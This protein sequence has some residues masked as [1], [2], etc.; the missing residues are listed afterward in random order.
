MPLIDVPHERERST[1]TDHYKDL[2]SG[3]VA[4][5]VFVSGRRSP[6]ELWQRIVN[7]SV[8]AYYEIAFASFGMLADRDMAI[9]FVATSE[10]SHMV[11]DAQAVMI[12]A[13]DASITTP[14]RI[15]DAMANDARPS[16]M[17]EVLR[18][19]DTIAQSDTGRSVFAFHDQG[20][21]HAVVRRFLS[22]RCMVSS[23]R[24]AVLA[25]LEAPSALGHRCQ[26]IQGPPGTGKTST[27]IPLLRVMLTLQQQTLCA[28]PS[29]V[30]VC[31]LASRTI[32][33]SLNNSGVLPP[34]P[35]SKYLL[36]GSATMRKA[37][38]S[39]TEDYLDRIYIESRLKRLRA[40]AKSWEGSTE[41]L[42]QL[43]D[44]PPPNDSAACSEW[45]HK[46]KTTVNIATAEIKGCARVVRDEAPINFCER[47]PGELIRLVEELG[48]LKAALEAGT[49]PAVINTW[50]PCWVQAAQVMSLLRGRK[51][52]PVFNLKA[53]E[54]RVVDAASL[55]FCTVS[56]RGSKAMSDKCFDVVIIDEAAQ[57]VEAE[58]LIVLAD[59]HIKMLTLCGDHKQL[60]GTVISQ[61]AQS[62]GYGRSLFERVFLQLQRREQPDNL[63]FTLLDT[64]FRMH[65]SISAW[66]NQRFYAGRLNDGVN[67]A[68]RS[69]SLHA[70]VPVCAVYDVSWGQEERAD[71]HSVYNAAEAEFVVQL[72]KELRSA[73]TSEH[74]PLSVGIITPYRAHAE[75]LRKRVAS[76]SRVEIQVATVD[77]FQGKEVDAVIFSSVRVKNL[78]FT[79]DERRLN[80]AITRPRYV[81]AIVCHETTM[82]KSPLWKSLIDHIGSTRA[83]DNEEDRVKHV[84]VRSL[85]DKS[86]DEFLSEQ[87]DLD[88]LLNS[89]NNPFEDNPWRVVI[90]H[91]MKKTISTVSRSERKRIVAV[92]M[93]LLKG[94]WPKHERNV[95]AASGLRLYQI[96]PRFLIWAVDLDSSTLTQQLRF[97]QLADS[98]TSDALVARIASARL[99]TSRDYLE[100]CAATR[101][102][103]DHVRLPV[104]W[105]EALPP[106][107]LQAAQAASPSDGAA[108]GEDGL[109]NEAVCLMKFHPL[110]SVVARLLIE[111][112][113]E[114][115]LL[116]QM[117]PEET[118]LAKSRESCFIIGR[119][120]TGKTT[121]ML[122]RMITSNR[123]FASLLDG[124]L[125]G[126][127]ENE[128]TADS[129]S[130]PGTMRQILVTASPM[131]RANIAAYYRKVVQTANTA[132]TLQQDSLN[133]EAEADAAPADD[134]GGNSLPTS[135][136][137]GLSDV[138]LA[139]YPLFCTHYDM[140]HLLDR[141]LHQPY[142][143]SLKM[144]ACEVTYPRFRDEYF[145][146]LPERLTRQ[147][148]VVMMWGEISELKGSLAAI[149]TSS[150]WMA[151]EDYLALAGTRSSQLDHALRELV[152]DA[153]HKY[154]RF[155]MN[156]GN[157]DVHDAVA[158]VHRE[159]R[160]GRLRKPVGIV[161]ELFTDE[162]QDL[163]PGQVALL[164][165]FGEDE[166]GFVFAGD[167]A[168][169]IAPGIR[170]RFETLRD[171]FYDFF[172]GGQGKMPETHTLTLNFRTHAGVIGVA[173]MVVELIK[174]FHPSSMDSN[175]PPEMAQ[176]IGELP[177]LLENTSLDAATGGLL[178]QLFGNGSAS[179]GFGS[180]QAILVRD[181][182]TRDRVRLAVGDNALVFNAQECKGLEFEDVLIF[183]FFSS[184]TLGSRWRVAYQYVAE[185]LA[186]GCDESYPAFDLK[187]HMLLSAELKE[188]YV[189]ATRAKQRLLIYD[190]DADL[191]RPV[192]EIL[193]RSSLVRKEPLGART[194]ESFAVSSTSDQWLERGSEL[195]KRELFQQA[196]AAFSRGHDDVMARLSC[197]KGHEQEARRV[198]LSS[199]EAAQRMFAEAA[200]VYEELYELLTKLQRT[201][202]HPEC[203]RDAA[204]CYRRAG[205]FERAVRIFVKLELWH[206]AAK[207][208]EALKKW[209]SAAEAHTRR[210]PSAL[211]DLERCC[212]EKSLF[213]DALRLI[214]K[215]YN[216]AA[217]SAERDDCKSRIFVI[218]REGARYYD[219]NDRLEQLMNCV[220]RFETHE[221]KQRF[222]ASHERLLQLVEIEEKTERWVA[223]GSA[224][225]AMARYVEAA[226]A[227]R[228]AEQPIQM[229]RALLRS[230]RCRLL[231]E[232]RR[233]LVLGTPSDADQKTLLSAVKVVPEGATGEGAC[234]VRDELLMLL[235]L[236]SLD[237]Q[238]LRQQLVRVRESPRLSTLLGIHLIDLVTKCDEP[239]R[240]PLN[241]IVDVMEIGISS[242]LILASALETPND[243]SDPSTCWKDALEVFELRAH[244][245]KE[246]AVYLEQCIDDSILA[247]LKLPK[248]EVSRDETYARWEC[249]LSSFVL[250]SLAIFVRE[251]LRKLGEDCLAILE[252][253]AQA[254]PKQ[255]GDLTVNTRRLTPIAS[256][257]RT[258]DTCTLL[259]RASTLL[260]RIN[261]GLASSAQTL[262]IS[263]LLPVM[264]A[265]EDHNELV[266]ARRHSSVTSAVLV[267][268]ETASRSGDFNTFHD[269]VT[270]HNLLVALGMN[271]S[272]FSQMLNQGKLYCQRHTI[273]SSIDVPAEPDVVRPRGRTLDNLILTAFSSISQRNQ[274][275]LKTVQEVSNWLRK[276]SKAE[277][278]LIK[279]QTAEEQANKELEKAKQELAS[280]T[281][282]EEQGKRE[283]GATNGM[284][285]ATKQASKEERK[286]QAAEEV[287]DKQEA[288]KKRSKAVKQLSQLDDKIFATLP[289]FVSQVE[290]AIIEALLV[291]STV[292]FLPISLLIETLSGRDKHSF[293]GKILSIS[294]A[295]VQCR[296]PVEILDQRSCDIVALLGEMLNGELLN[297]WSRVS[298][299]DATAS[300]DCCSACT[301]RLLLLLLVCKVN[302]EYLQVDSVDIL[303]SQIQHFR[304]KSSPMLST[305]QQLKGVTNSLEIRRRLAGSL[306]SAGEKLV[307]VSLREAVTLDLP[308]LEVFA[309][310]LSD[311]ITPYPVEVATS[312]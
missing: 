299:S 84:A 104:S 155:K 83:S 280:A 301:S 272:R 183:D 162:V 201:H 193:L 256:S 7:E 268:L 26:L 308:H 3:G 146:R 82:R 56:T 269:C 42:Q 282:A 47:S 40:L 118:R 13:V 295:A 298:S 169:V 230:V 178:T 196:Q 294:N 94:R 289:S 106:R 123:I 115:E 2:V 247:E 159:I 227:Y 286:T 168:Q 306:R 133:E 27:L 258:Y 149:S 49:T 231:N 69:L 144:G 91:D 33:D 70:R 88:Q 165:Y 85:M 145:L 9:E 8:P 18:M 293:P 285:Q 245:S 237:V 50:S 110:N 5:L 150:G 200:K 131:L 78:G 59:P 148:D 135:F 113:E 107:P 77:G 92:F 297:M 164:K 17:A 136:T 264:L 62:K 261:G 95:Q 284:K 21:S 189:L 124:D 238:T 232:P 36:M 216:V 116:Y 130:G 277:Q 291:N 254:R 234:E 4:L 55:V 213:V 71:G 303:C 271:E 126:E 176:V 190:T 239:Q 229:A 222:L 241:L 172:M 240:P 73:T 58:T 127:D 142:F 255:R 249:E 305:L 275:L 158:H 273:A 192:S 310:R 225:T 212:R 194:L 248:R 75:L 250:K 270:A 19:P 89:K 265:H 157:Y 35:L 283:A 100:R 311:K 32:K 309:F 51:G 132:R 11:V 139:W 102:S 224:L 48:I 186:G 242:A 170:F 262:L 187:K 246:T 156:D 121:V 223:A 243:Q 307:A 81:L 76:C 276:L 220:Q 171:V 260:C 103:A 208:F 279:A 219:K 217:E 205:N 112:D 52:G 228:K 147:L 67:S 153:A 207:C 173:N 177:V 44:E 174:F 202:E 191:A 288:V 46:L 129:G 37:V 185:R 154:E 235:N 296:L 101:A 119:S 105:S 287:K 274:T 312:A 15:C 111:S 166:A 23:Q 63:P 137:G 66:P 267:W 29:N 152:Y 31:E 57:L 195:F 206:D 203:Y 253:K 278:E 167:T 68:S 86:R 292:L 263:R 233:A 251:R 259:A 163:T 236:G 226:G 16:F 151:K 39:A 64:Q 54:R 6:E 25:V 180:E 114:L 20:E 122:Q 53:L 244:A 175:L 12:F 98:R 61:T 90:S 302:I 108:Q 138:P 80:V 120:G 266:R 140:L 257:P 218:A 65:P 304:L 117:S 99:C 30:A 160:A 60:P 1:W 41:K 214:D 161:N 179:K 204:D 184:S 199:P 22:E 45:W 197:A 290:R 97:Y 93:R 215:I 188:L 252:S 198:N 79:R 181:D 300:E 141:S 72:V 134:C 143:A 96:G 34:V 74:C 182:A 109:L 211:N 210:G 125:Q 28:A 87:Q 221:D 43:L 38:T 128:E 14:Q 10:E 209:L 281:Q 24:A